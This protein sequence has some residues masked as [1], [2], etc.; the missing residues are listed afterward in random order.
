MEN[1]KDRRLWVMVGVP[2]SGKSTFITTHINF[3]AERKAVIS[4]DDIRFSMLKEGESYFSKEKEVFVEFIRQIKDSLN[5][6]IDTIVDATHISSASRG[7]LLRALG[8]SLKNVQINAI[9]IKVPLEIALERNKQREGI[10]VVP[11]QAIINMNSQFTEPT[12]DEGFD[13]I[14]INEGET[15]IYHKTVWKIIRKEKI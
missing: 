2:G 15:Y 3:F 7:K 8:N 13:N 14:W 4:R 1:L 5:K 9:V 6:N 12:L 11:D 10:K